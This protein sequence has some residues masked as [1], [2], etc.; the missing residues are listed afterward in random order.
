MFCVSLFF[1]FSV[2]QQSLLYKFQS[3]EGP[4]MLLIISEAILV[5]QGKKS[6]KSQ[7]PEEN[8]SFQ[9]ESTFMKIYRFSIGMKYS[10]EAASC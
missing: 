8:K 5:A 4:I 7:S 3:D 6:A 1:G 9:R 2:S 10:N